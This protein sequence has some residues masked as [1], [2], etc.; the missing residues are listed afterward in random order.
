MRGKHIVLAAFGPLIAI[1]LLTA[2][3][4]GATSHHEN[5]QQPTAAS[6]EEALHS[7]GS[8]SPPMVELIEDYLPNQM[9]RWGIDGVITPYLPVEPANGPPTELPESLVVR[10]TAGE[11]RDG[12]AYRE[13]GGPEEGVLGFEQT[14]WDDPEADWRTALIELDITHWLGNNERSP[15]VLE[16]REDIAASLG[17]VSDG[18]WSLYRYGGEGPWSVSVVWPVGPDGKL[19]FGND[20]ELGR[21][22]QTI[23]Q[24]ISFAEGPGEIVTLDPSKRSQGA[25]VLDRESRR[26]S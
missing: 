18:A 22:V 15:V 11:I 24:L 5:A 13:T 1:S 17:Q 4:G 9:R 14:T 12:T 6:L 26:R 25:V 21:R 7:G 10:A 3:C 2:G 19:D 8:T 16:V 23:D 20:P